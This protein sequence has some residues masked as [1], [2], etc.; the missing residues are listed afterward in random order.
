MRYEFIV[1]GSISRAVEAALPDMSSAPYPTGGSVL[2]GPVRDDA[3][4]MTMFARICSLGLSV[5]EIRRLPD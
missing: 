3:D 5:V 1:K 4:V 2:F